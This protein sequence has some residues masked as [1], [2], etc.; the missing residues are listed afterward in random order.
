MAFSV[1][2]MP[3]ALLPDMLGQNGKHRRK[4][5]KATAATKANV[6]QRRFFIARIFWGM[7]NFDGWWN[8]DDATITLSITHQ[9]D[10][11]LL[12]FLQYEIRFSVGAV[13]LELFLIF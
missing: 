13:V 5:W 4:L 9:N 10:R 7:R 11:K 8:G 2:L 1:H 12:L 6:T 3:A